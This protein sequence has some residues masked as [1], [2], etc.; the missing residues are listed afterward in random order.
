MYKYKLVDLFAGAGGLSYGFLQTGKFKVEMAVEINDSAKETYRINHNN[1]NVDIRGNILDVDFKQ[2]KK[3]HGD[4]DFVIG[5]PPCQGFSNANRQKSTLISNNNKLVKEYIR[6]IEELRPK[7][8]VL[9]NVKTMDSKTHKFY[10][11]KN[12]INDCIIKGLQKKDEKVQVS[13][14]SEIIKD[15]KGLI[16]DIYKGKSNINLYLLDENIVAF[17]KNISKTKQLDSYID[18]NK[19]IWQITKENWSRYHNSYINNKY[20]ELFNMLYGELNAKSYDKIIEISDKITNVQKLLYKLKEVVDN[21]II[22]NNFDL[23]GDNVIFE[24][25]SYNIFSYVKQKLSSLG[26]EVKPYILN[27]ADYGVAQLRNRLI[28]I[29][30]KEELLNGKEIEAPKVIYTKDQYMK[31]GDAIKDLENYEVSYNVD[32]KS[33]VIR[34]KNFVYGKLNGYLA[35]SEIISNMIT[36]E[37]RKIAMD[38]FKALKP[39]ENFHSLDESLKTTYAQPSRTQSSIYKR[40]DYTTTCGTVT[41]VRKSM[42]IHPKKDRALSIREAAR[43]QSF[44]DSF[45]FAGTKDQQ[46]QQIGNAVPPMLARVIAEKVLNLIGDKANES[47]E[48][49]LKR[50]K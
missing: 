16:V 35:D 24:M 45:E 46:Y 27:A 26:Y 1:E 28:V 36:T 40:L 9:E 23:D 34:E 48:D 37:T 8:F 6:A 20:K 7:G 21:K 38:R 17:I 3:I 32:E 5:G 29:G 44:P 49:I 47:L 41:N 14:N 10:L 15:T 4:I 22:V 18:N 33:K 25:V 12:D 19:S 11:S 13:I 2:V 39:G 31:I 43:L 50:G 42:W 30:I